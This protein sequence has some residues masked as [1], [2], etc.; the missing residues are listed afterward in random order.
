[1]AAPTKTAPSSNGQAKDEVQPI[2]SDWYY[3]WRTRIFDWVKGHSNST[4]ASVVLMIPD[5]LVLAIGLVRDPRVPLWTKVKVGLVI[6]YV[7]SPIDL[8]PEF[9][10]GFFGLAED[11]GL[12]VG[13]LYGL[14]NA[15]GV[16]PAVLRA[17]WRGEGDVMDVLL[18]AQNL[19]E[20]WWDK[21]TPMSYMGR[22]FRRGKKA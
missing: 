22:L 18:R 16:D 17:H 10:L 15:I 2:Q 9:A 20:K 7:L 1:M 3:R 19:F 21:I 13:V 12:L 6:L 8:L 5:L 14:R 4:L 11:T